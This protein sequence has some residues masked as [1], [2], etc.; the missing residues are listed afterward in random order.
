MK[1]QSLDTSIEAERVQIELLRNAS[2]AKRFAL[3]RM[4]TNSTRK[5]AKSAIKKCNP[6]KDQRELDLIF[7]EVT[8]G[9][10]LAEQLRHYFSTKEKNE[11]QN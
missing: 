6:G 7:V 8:Y 4:L 3:A 11:H 2:V 10:D 9:K 5:M 1:P